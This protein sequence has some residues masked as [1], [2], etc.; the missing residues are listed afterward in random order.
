MAKQNI[1]ESILCSRQE[2]RQ[3]QFLKDIK[4]H[5]QVQQ[6]LKGICF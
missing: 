2:M 3:S 4:S 5:V 6:T 1:N